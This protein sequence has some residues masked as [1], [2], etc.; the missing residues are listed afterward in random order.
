MCFFFL[1]QKKRSWEQNSYQDPS[2]LF[3]SSGNGCLASLGQELSHTAGQKSAQVS[4]W[5]KEGH[6][7]PAS[8]PTLRA[9]HVSQTD[10][11]HFLHCRAMDESLFVSACQDYSGKWRDYDMISVLIT[12]IGNEDKGILKHWHNLMVFVHQFAF[13]LFFISLSSHPLWNAH[14]PEE[15]WLCTFVHLLGQSIFT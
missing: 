3:P 1:H 2:P 4:K 11:K 12:V 8:V 15:E 6:L 10:K 7:G 13:L 9:A 14:S 5:L